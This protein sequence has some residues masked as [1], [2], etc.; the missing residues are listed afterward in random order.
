MFKL[1]VIEKI[2]DSCNAKKHYQSLLREE[3]AKL[4][5]QSKIITQKLTRLENL[6]YFHINP[7]LKLLKLL[8]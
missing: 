3:N 7:K 6:K 5:K 2:P 4:V 8:Y 1:K